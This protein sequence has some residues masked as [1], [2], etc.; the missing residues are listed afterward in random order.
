[1][2]SRVI[3]LTEKIETSV[4]PVISRTTASEPT[5]ARAPTMAGM[6]AATR[7]PKIRKA[8]RITIGQRDLLGPAEVLRR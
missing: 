7:L 8:S 2:P 5:T 3:T 6:A 4:K 1:M